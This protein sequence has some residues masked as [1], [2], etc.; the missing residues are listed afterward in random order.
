MT[1]PDLAHALGGNSRFEV[2]RVLG[3]GGMGTVYEA[4]DRERA[5][6]VALK[7]LR[8]VHPDTRFRFKHEFRSLQDI[9]HP[10]LVSLGEMLEENGHLFFTMELIDGVRFLEYVRGAVSS[11]VS[12]SSVRRE[13]VKTHVRKIVV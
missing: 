8:D 9:H 1:A 3:E 4:L 13:D 6:Y 2:I 7:T 5:T 11:P 10:N 12:E